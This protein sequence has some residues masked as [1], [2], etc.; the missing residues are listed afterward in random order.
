MI[1]L[2][3][4]SLKNVLINSDMH[5]KIAAI[6]IMILIVFDAI[7]V[8]TV[9]KFPLSA[10]LIAAFLVGVFGSIWIFKMI[11]ESL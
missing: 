7:M 8:Y 1:V 3:L 6:L 5:N 9:F 10:G 4:T 11:K 2:G